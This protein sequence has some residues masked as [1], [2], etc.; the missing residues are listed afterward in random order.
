MKVA[1]I[2]DWLNQN[3]GAER[4]LEEFHDIFPDAPIYTSMYDPQRM[5]VSYRQ[6]DIRVSWMQKLPGVTKRHQQYMPLYPMAFESFDLSGYDLVLS[7]SSAFCH[8][9][10]TRPET[11]HICYCY[12]PTRFMWNYFDYV[13]RE[14]LAKWQQRL[15]APFLF[16]L[17][18]WDRVSADRVDYWIGIS[19][20]IRDRIAKFYRRE[21]VVIFPPVD[22]SRFTPSDGHDDYFLALSRLIPYKRIDLAIEACNRLKARLLIAGSGRETER[23]KKLAGPTVEFLGRVPEERLNELY[24]RCKAFI[25]PGEEDF[26]LTPLE[27]NAAGRPVIAFKAGGT[28]DTVVPGVTGEYF[29]EQTVDNLTGVMERFDPDAYEPAAIRAHACKFDKSVFREQLMTQINRW[30][31]DYGKRIP[32]TP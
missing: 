31:G 6:W 5:P 27:A 1:I 30:M 24:A 16:Q 32:R 19:N 17:R 8:G 3:G 9:V 28:L 26:G 21:S 12:T 18:T 4:V 25:F 29:T 10:L 13:Q 22:T 23:L 7:S 20:L 11:C 14:G 15:L 2:H